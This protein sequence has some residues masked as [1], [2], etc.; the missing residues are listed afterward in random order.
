MHAVSVATQVELVDD[1]MVEEANEVRARADHERRVV[2]RVLERARPADA[3]ARFE[4]QHGAPRACQIGG[5]GESVV[6]GT[7]DNCVP[8]FGGDALRHRHA[9]REVIA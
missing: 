9:R 4:H 6:A 5:G 2:E 3:V 1:A 7:D 8:G